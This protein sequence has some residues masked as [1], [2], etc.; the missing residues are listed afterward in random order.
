MEE[1][2]RA[3][4]RRAS[5]RDRSR[6]LEEEPAAVLHHDRGQDQG[7]ELGRPLELAEF[8]QRQ[9]AEVLPGHLQALAPIDRHQ[10]VGGERDPRHVAQGDRGRDRVQ[11]GPRQLLQPRRVVRQPLAVGREGRLRLIVESLDVVAGPDRPGGA[12]RDQPERVAEVLSLSSVSSQSSTLAAQWAPR[13]PPPEQ[14]TTVS[15]GFWPAIPGFRLSQ[16]SSDS[17]LLTSRWPSRL[18]VRAPRRRGRMAPPDPSRR[19][20]TGRDWPPR[21]AGRASPARPGPDRRRPG[22]RTGA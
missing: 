22:Y 2:A 8:L 9:V 10:V 14:E 18:G 1:R 4:V 20:S 7:R 11:A 21:S 6:L 19:A 17:W 16:A 3:G 15:F 13:I 12:G 5:S